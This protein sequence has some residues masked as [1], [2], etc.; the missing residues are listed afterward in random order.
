MATDNSERIDRFLREQMSTEENEAFLHDL[1]ADRALR[2]DAQ[3]TALMIQELAARQKA[4]DAEIIS[5]VIAAKKSAQRAKVVRL[6]KWVG[7]VAAMLVLVFGVYAYLSEKPE[8]ADYIALAD[9]YY[10]E[11]PAPTF[12]SGDTDADKE[13]S[14]FFSQVG[15]S[16]DISDV[17]TR[18]QFIYDHLDSEYA[19]RAN[20]NDIRI[21]WYLALAYLKDNHP[22]KAT[23]LLQTIV[24]DDKGTDLG[25]IAKNLLNDIGAR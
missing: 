16:D 5:E 6:V 23:K 20:G 22:D 14:D 25:D 10:Q 4:K 17:I 18:L 3:L 21:T 15:K 9:H 7:S 11:T 2:E 24:Q 19:Y 12:R 8:Q 1:E 13:L